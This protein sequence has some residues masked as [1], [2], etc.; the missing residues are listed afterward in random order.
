M[1]V[2][3]YWRFGGESLSRTV[4]INQEAIAN[5]EVFIRYSELEDRTMGKDM[6]VAKIGT[7]I[8]RQIVSLPAG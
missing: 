7:Y 5:L 3:I 6:T 1:V 4:T 2:Y 8:M